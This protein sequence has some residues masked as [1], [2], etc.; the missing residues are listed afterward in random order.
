VSEYPYFFF[1]RVSLRP[2]HIR[3]NCRFNR[4]MLLDDERTVVVVDDDA[5]MRLYLTETLTSGGYG[6]RSFPDAL[7]AL[8]W[9]ASGE[10][11]ADLLLS[12]INMPGM[13]GLDLLRTVKAVSPGLPFI[14]LSGACELPMAQS[15]LRS[16]ATDYLLK[17]VRP[18][19]LLGLI[20]RYVDVDQSE[21]LQAVKQ[22]LKQS[23]LASRASDESQASRLLPI[24]EALG[25]K[26]FET[27]KHSQRVAA[28][29]LLIAR[30]LD[31]GPGG[32]RALETGSLLHDIGKAGI[33]HN[34]LMKPGKLTHAERTIIQMHPQLGLDLL[35]GMPGLEREAAIVFSHHESFD[36]KGY[37][38]Q[39][40][41]EEIPLN[42][43]VFSVADTLD[44]LT[45]D[46]CYRLG[47]GIPAARAEI[48]RFAGSQFDPAIIEL[49]DRVD[50]GDL[51]AVRKEFPDIL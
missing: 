45:S 29:A 22:A 35:S 44:A 30:D 32:L 19:D 12:D 51:D 4:K 11:R 25:F 27:L 24:F 13:S 6:C 33:P 48:H 49:F 21:K 20:T 3:A 8:G 39:L 5:A 17:P 1:C 34:V 14:L 47:Q 36:G 41:G 10:A 2:K 28:F 7:A 42:A 46:R 15:A 9:L 43:R 38:R 16:G 37:P 26:R 50:D 31:L 40:A 23:L 18:A